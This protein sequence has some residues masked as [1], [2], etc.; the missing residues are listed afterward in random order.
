MNN[1]DFDEFVLSEMPH[2]IAVNYQQLLRAETPQRQ[3]EL[4]L[5]IYNL[6]LR[7]LAVGL[8]SQYL[9]RDSDKM[10]DPYLNSLLLQKFPHLTL[11]TWQQ[12]FFAALRAYEGHQHLFF[13][14]ELY[15][16]YW[17]TSTLPHKCRIEAEEPFSRLSQIAMNLR[18]E[19]LRP[20][21][22][23][24]WEKLAQE[25]I[26]LLKQFLDSLGFIENYDLI[27]ILDYDDQFYEF[28]LGK[29]VAISKQRSP[30]PRHIQLKRG[31][32][33]LRKKTEEF[34]LLHPFLVFHQEEYPVETKNNE[35]A[36]TNTAIYERFMYERLYY[37]VA[38]PSQPFVFHDE[39]VAAFVR[40]V[41][42]TI[43]ELKRVR[44]EIEKL[45]WW[46]LRDICL[47]ITAHR[48][49]AVQHKY[50]HELY[51]QRNKTYQ[52]FNNFLGSEKR[53][54]V[55]IGK[56]GVG[57]SNFLL[58]MRE[59]LQKSD[60]DVCML[61]YDGAALK[62][63]PSITEV[64]NQDFNDRLNLAG[65]QI[66]DVW[67]EMTK[68]DR[69][70][71]RRVILCVDAVNENPQAQELLR[72]LDAL[73]QRPL[74]WLKIV[75]SSRPET[76]QAIKRGLRLAEG[77]Y[78]RP[79]ED[80]LP[81][82][83]LEPFS[84]SEQMDP[85]T[86]QE[87]PLAYANYK[88]M[89]D[90]QTE[91]QA[92]PAELREMLR[93][94][95]SLWLVAKIYKGQAIS[96]GLKPTSL[97]EKY[98]DALLA[99]QRLRSEDVR[100][101]QRQL[102][103]LLVREN[104]YSNVITPADIDAAGDD[105]YEAVYSEQLLS[106]GQRMNQS[107]ANLLDAE[108]LTRYLE[109][110][111]EKIV[112]K[113]ERFY[114]H[115]MG[116][117]LV[118]MCRPVDD[119]MAFFEGVMAQLKGKIFLWGALSQLL[120]DLLTEKDYAVIEKLGQTHHELLAELLVN[121]LAEHY[122][123]HRHDLKPI[124][125]TWL[126]DQ[127]SRSRGPYITANIAIICLIEDVLE[128]TLVHSR[129]AIRFLLVQD[130]HKLWK[131][132][133]ELTIRILQALPRQISLLHLKHSRDILNTLLHISVVL[134]SRDYT[135]MGVTTATLPVVR[136]LW[137][138]IIEK[139]FLVSR[140]DL[141]ESMMR[142]LRRL[143]VR[144]GAG[145]VINMLRKA[146]R[147]T[148]TFSFND[149]AA[150]F[151]ASER[152]KQILAYLSS[153]LDVAAGQAPGAVE[154]LTNYIANLARQ[155]EDN[156]FIGYAALAGLTA[157]LKANPLRTA[158]A[159]ETLYQELAALYQPTTDPKSPTAALWTSI[160]TAPF[161]TPSYVDMTPE[162][163]K[164]LIEIYAGIVRI[165]IFNYYNRS[166][167]GSGDILRLGDV[168]NALFGYH[169]KLPEIGRD[170]LT[171]IANIAVERNDYDHLRV[172]IAGI[173]M[174]MVRFKMPQAGVEALQ[175]FIQILR[176]TRYLERRSQQEQDEFWQAAADALI[177]RAHLYRHDIL[178]LLARLEPGEVPEEF[179]IRIRNAGR[180]ESIDFNIGEAVIW[181]INKALQDEN[182]FLRN[183]IKWVFHTAANVRSLTELA[184][185]LIIYLIGF[186]DEGETFFSESRTPLK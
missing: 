72:Q 65:R 90:L 64:I 7:T 60:E 87:L 124:L 85:F 129:E 147:E 186:I 123:E 98:I 168:D 28:E 73:V 42:D 74:P 184:V 138:P 111:A 93:D 34:L 183:F 153:H 152:Q 154:D 166:R 156:V 61:L 45:T 11:D 102:V 132:D 33:Y 66:D 40:I 97:I 29:G 115:F 80:K 108:I 164:P 21:R 116:K 141:I 15:E 95:L 17:D 75:L 120:I 77:F 4:A 69:I 14:S 22:Q 110:R 145:L 107:F 88:K 170:F 167:F 37:M 2:F 151:P 62:V 109:G 63:E 179:K 71:E 169:F 158:Q 161:L 100:F 76:W 185:E 13:I 173:A 128:R 114:D 176:Q 27:R 143:L 180:K 79:G 92:L 1:G 70:D 56:S 10:S 51:L 148:F 86:R 150:F 149:A 117:R 12:L 50:N 163:A 35:F 172:A 103:P 139:V 146:Q 121:V 83:E 6:G 134:V 177:E 126:A 44:Q 31:Q 54:F 25:T 175:D 135:E 181:A 49:A 30:L 57:K 38:T 52:S 174:S 43:E 24:D 81:E 105:L 23:E 165:R 5:H 94:P 112:F 8:V 159:I 104:D 58:A 89:F 68:V 142:P 78:Y 20:Q 136:S 127:D 133:R 48:I 178:D 55:L 137:K 118:E 84:Y 26:R 9:I 19:E 36:L 122:P 32:F 144:L 46:Q 82:V 91:Y 39:S 3:I 47:D 96:P 160:V 155:G 157:H 171:D 113:Y 101:L 182:P 119:K 125:I 53:C 67:H 162:A 18:K 130:I 16:L 99:E 131:Q 106:N 59:E 41:Y 140:N